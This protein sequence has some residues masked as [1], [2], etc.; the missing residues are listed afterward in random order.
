[1]LSHENQYARCALGTAFPHMPTDYLVV[2]V[3][4][5]KRC[6]VRRQAVW[7]SPGSTPV[8]AIGPNQR[9]PSQKKRPVL[10]RPPSM[11]DLN[12]K[13][14]QIEALPVLFR[15]STGR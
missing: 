10:A 5:T 11:L 1:M 8:Y 7:A 4:A 15:Q 13:Y 3:P 12:S 9:T 14:W 6:L 2:R